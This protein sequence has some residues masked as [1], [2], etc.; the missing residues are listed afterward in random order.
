MHTFDPCLK[1]LTV[2]LLVYL[3]RDVSALT[4]PSSVR[5]QDNEYSGVIVAIHPDVEENGMVIERIKVS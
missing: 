2:V 4:K 3:F 5:L 1:G